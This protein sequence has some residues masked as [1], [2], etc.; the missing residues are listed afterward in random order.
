[1][2]RT[3]APSRRAVFLDVDGTYAHHGVVPSAHVEVVRAARAAGHLVLLCTGRPVSLLPE[4]ITE[5]GFDGYVAG[6]GAYVSLGGEVL[7]D[8]R[9]PEGLATRTLDA[10]DAH[11]TLYF[12]ESPEHTWARPDVAAAMDAYLPHR[13]ALHEDGTPDKAG[14][15][16]RA[17]L[18]VREDLRGLSFAK[19]TSFH[20]ETPLGDIAAQIGP[21]LAVIPSSIEG[22]GPGAG[23]M[24]LAH[25]DKS[26]GIRVVE[27]ALGL[28]REQLIA[29]GDGLNDLEMLAYAGI[30]VA[31]DG[32]PPAVAAAADRTAR[33]PLENGLV[34]A[35]AQL[36]LLD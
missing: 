26:V 4:S 21:E 30:G 18:T 17:H 32:G 27:E 13:R 12:L 35:F 8:E 29:F 7:R 23:E 31:V 2:T 19:V 28:A 20:A 16:I 22:L 24:Y 3:L 1:M 6:A 5:A 36:G 9:F 10:L 11:G 33:G 14:R 15:D 34:E 25:V